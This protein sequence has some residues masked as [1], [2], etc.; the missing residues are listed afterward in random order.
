MTPTG[1][2]PGGASL[3]GLF[4]LALCMA[5]CTPYGTLEPEPE[6][7]VGGYFA[8][9]RV[10]DVAIGIDP[11]DWDSLRNETRT[12][13]DIL[14]GDCL[15]SPPDDIFSFFPAEVTVDG[16]TLTEVGVRKKGFLGSLSTKKPS[17]KVRFDK[18]VDGQLLGG[19]MKRL[20]LN[21]V[22]Q[23]PSRLN[24]CMTYK[25]FADAGMPSPRCNF[26][27]VS[28]NGDN[29]GLYV[30][31]ESIKKAFLERSFE[32]PEGNLYEG[33]LSDFR[34]GW[35]GTFE[36]KTN[37]DQ[38]DWSDIDD[39]VSALELEGAEG[40]DALDDIIDTD[41]F[42]TFWALEV[43]TGLWDGYS[44]NRNNFYIYRE[45]NGRFV[46]M[47]WGPDSA[48]A[49]I[50]HRFAEGNFP[51]AVMARG[52][53]AHRLYRDRDSQDAYIE[54]LQE[55]L[56]TAWNEWQLLDEID[57][58]ADIVQRHALPDT[59]LAAQADTSRLRDFVAYRRDQVLDELSPDPPDWSWPLDSPDI[60]WEELGLVDLEFE[61]AWDTLD[62]DVT[63]TG[64]VDVLNY[65]FEGEA[66]SF[67]GDGAT[68]GIETE[69]EA[70]GAAALRIGNILPDGTGD[71]LFIYTWPDLLTAGA[72]LP[73]DE[74]VTSGFRVLVPP[75]YDEL[76][77]VAR[78][79]SGALE[80]DRASTTDGAA[81][82]GRIHGSFYPF[83][84]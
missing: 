84:R 69:G 32:D 2:S 81:I 4:L 57:R 37:E 12:I 79:G 41:R 76:H 29:L 59:R 56:D 61:A 8:P 75:P 39:V 14:G 31:V 1:G 70:A 49:P 65:I 77:V 62:D 54:R 42:L 71:I 26:A 50:E 3:G 53:V 35:Q 48:F 30:H 52:A 23:D 78:L 74:F 46:F 11:D 5:A 33:T 6:G 44:G 13:S 64:D 21:N 82:S 36:K 28:V 72:T 40:L 45:S 68:A 18:F 20:T 60:C 67:V 80:L 22:Q 27:T 7:I 15:G 63:S 43:I 47:P 38:N 10:L 55:L 66:L 9:D 34:P 19:E 58:M 17:L 16:D 73:F 83:E 51:Q 24:T 25:V